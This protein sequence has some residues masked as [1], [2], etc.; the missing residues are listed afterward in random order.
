MANKK[1]Y[2]VISTAL[3]FGLLTGCG[4][5]TKTNDTSVG[6][7][8]EN[9]KQEKVTATF[10]PSLEIKEHIHDITVKY[11]VKN[12]SGKK[13]TL[14]FSNGLKADFIVYDHDG[15]KVK[16]YSEGVSTTQ[17]TEEISLDNN[18]E[19]EQEFSISDL[20]NGQYKLEVYLT[21][22][23]EKAKTEAE[24]IV[25][26]SLFTNG[27]GQYVGQMD[28]HTIEVSVDGNKTAFQLS[29]EAINQLTTIKEGDQISFI[30]SEKESG[31]KTIERFNKED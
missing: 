10:I 11:A 16:Q 23:E 5:S 4:T 14:T 29:D 17:A 30:Y 18:K 7:K 20:P 31:Q 22:K 24:F 19:M 26:N 28:P 12:I 6:T 21:S 13:Q 8:T 27:S 2:F 15:K 3:L 9:Q 1:I 25:K